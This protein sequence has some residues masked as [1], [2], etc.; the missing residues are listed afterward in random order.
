M[1]LTLLLTILASTVSGARERLSLDFGWRFTGFNATG[2][3]RAHP[4]PPAPDFPES[5]WPEVASCGYNDSAWRAVD[6][7]HDFVI[8]KSFDQHDTTGNG[9]HGF[10]ALGVGWYRHNFTLNPTQL[11]PVAWVDFEGVYRNAT[12]WLNGKELGRHSSGYTSF[13]FE[14]GDV[15]RAGTNTL[16]VRADA[17]KLEGWFYEGGGI[18]RHVWLT[19]TSGVHVSPMHGVRVI[20]HVDGTPARGAAPVSLSVQVALANVGA[21]PRAVQVMTEVFDDGHSLGNTSV[22]LTVQK[23]LFANLSMHIGTV[24]LWSIENPVLYTLQ[25]SLV[26]DNG[27]GG[28]QVLDTV[29]T[30]FGPRSVVFNA[31]TGLYLNGEHVKL[32]GMANHM[33]FAGVGNAVPDRVQR[34]KISKMKAMGA[35][36]WRCAHNPPAA[37]F[38][39]AADEMGLLVLDENRHFGIQTDKALLF[40]ASPAAWSL[41]NQADFRAMIARD[42]NHPSVIAWSLCNEPECYLQNDTVSAKAGA[43][44]K[45]MQQ[46]L[47]PSRGLTGGMTRDWGMG[48][49]SVLD[50]QG[51]NYN[52]DSYDGFHSAHPNTPVLATE[53]WSGL[54]DRG[55][56][57][58]WGPSDRQGCVGPNGYQSSLDSAQETW[59]RD[60]ATR[61]WMLGGF[62][63]T[64]FDYK[65][66]SQWPS[67]NS[68]FG[69]LD[70]AG[71]P[72]DRFFWYQ[73]QWTDQ[74]VL[75]I[76]GT[77]F[78]DTSRRVMVFTNAPEVELF[79]A[80]NTSL[81]RKR[82]PPLSH[83]NWT[84]TESPGK[85][86]TA[87]GYRSST[88][89]APFITAA[90][91][92]TGPAVAVR[93][94]WE[95]NQT[96][97]HADGHDVAL[98]TVSVVD[99]A[100]RVVP[101]AGHYL[102][103][104]VTGPGKI[105]GVGNGDPH[106]HEPDK[107]T[108]RSAFHGLAR[109]IVQ[110]SGRG[111]GGR[112]ELRASA[113]GLQDGQAKI[114]CDV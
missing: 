24:R 114:G 43:L 103:F 56:Y 35:N 57:G 22:S 19:L 9:D 53:N 81:G 15:L 38:L 79:D 58:C 72:K 3:P 7:P 99:A 66:E 26:V 85:Q 21:T 33:D 95:M 94:A 109:V 49:G 63:W 44:Y 2:S 86:L 42:R 110:S 74:P 87:Q 60:E 1:S 51:F 93:V 54:S 102:S 45:A 106:C 111:L 92:A 112:I 71:F 108:A 82:V 14:V 98:A 47:D 13:R 78:N 107:A 101:D 84:L 90:L 5:K 32:Q 80:Q 52:D 88:D 28:G 31:S 37:A 50:I 6:V 23:S 12:V 11:Q 48:L 75:H 83:Q 64:G 55:E 100:G 16:V 70:L 29:T 59:W 25:T 61:P 76:F 89:M 69:C 65:G 8:E 77:P 10:L 27:D 46:E 67:V 41:E 73:A 20:S 18:Y 68:H 104:E 97:I 105:I 4:S 113:E 39:D 40:S 30:R 62:A 91:F 17:T 34:F 36:A 96:S